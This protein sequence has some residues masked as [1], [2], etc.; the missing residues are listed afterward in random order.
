MKQDL[1]S[2][3]ARASNSAF[4][5]GGTEFGDQK[6][7]WVSSFQ[8]HSN[9][10]FHDLQFVVSEDTEYG[11]LGCAASI[12]RLLFASFGGLSGCQV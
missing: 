3:S 5:V 4:A 6:E 10:G 2:V 9:I 12:S 11:K 8:G 7:G 1:C